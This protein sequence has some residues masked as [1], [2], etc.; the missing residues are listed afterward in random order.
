MVIFRFGDRLFDLMNDNRPSNTIL[1]LI[2]NTATMGLNTNDYFPFI[3]Y[4]KS[5]ARGIIEDRFRQN[6]IRLIIA[7]SDL[8]GKPKVI[9]MNLSS[10]NFVQTPPEINNLEISPC[11]IFDETVKEG[12][13]EMNKMRF[14]FNRDQADPFFNVRKNDYY[15]ILL[16]TDGRTLSTSFHKFS[17]NSEWLFRPDENIYFCHIDKCDSTKNLI[18]KFNDA[19][20]QLDV[21]FIPFNAAYSISSTTLI[22]NIIKSKFYFHFCLNFGPLTVKA[23]VEAMNNLPWPFPYDSTVNQTSNVMPLY[24]CQKYKKLKSLNKIKNVKLDVFP[25]LGDRVES[26]Y[27]LLMTSVENGASFALLSVKTDKT[28]LIL[29]PYNFKK[30][31]QMMNPL[32]SKSHC[33]EYLSTIPWSYIE[34]IITFFTDNG[35]QFTPELSNRPKPKATLT[36]QRER[37]EFY[38]NHN[39][40]PEMM[41]TQTSIDSMKYCHNT[42]YTL[43][44]EMP[45]SRCVFH[46]KKTQKPFA[47]SLDTIDDRNFQSLDVVRAKVSPMLIYQKISSPV[48]EDLVKSM[49][50]RQNDTKEAQAEVAALTESIESLNSVDD[51]A[52]Q[53]VFL[54]DMLI[55]LRER[56]TKELERRLLMLQKNVEL[57]EFVKMFLLRAVRRFGL[58]H[59]PESTLKIL[60]SS[61]PKS[62]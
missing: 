58:E 11:G 32:P 39:L 25:K 35:F 40:L 27:Y 20:E 48:S 23:K 12:L 60:T 33:D 42:L 4:A 22:S 7:Y 55:T 62:E 15:S 16:F 46:L 19:N 49:M 53:F 17:E 26:G 57:Y 54:E 51:D 38:K 45:Q 18:P 14:Q 2:D 3:S 1:L 47:V 8:Y 56:D 30:L 41:P 21:E 43:L 10:M 50:P 6:K 34:G 37:D 52:D 13:I 59:L 24:F 31:L 36:K 29:L 9:N 61:E 44:E 28:S 5:T